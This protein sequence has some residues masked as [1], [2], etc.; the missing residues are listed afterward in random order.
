VIECLGAVAA[1]VLT[2]SFLHFPIVD[3]VL[4]LA[5]G[6]VEGKTRNGNLCTLRAAPTTS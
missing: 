5:G 6:G 4:V 1:L 2:V 3:D